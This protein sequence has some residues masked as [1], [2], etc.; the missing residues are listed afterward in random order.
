M[1]GFRI[2]IISSKYETY[3]YTANIGTEYWAIRN[4]CDTHYIIIS[5]GTLPIKQYGDKFVDDADVIV[6]QTANI[7][8]ESVAMVKIID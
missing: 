6:L 3:W 4:E 5:E 2:K 8:V 1:I 7:K